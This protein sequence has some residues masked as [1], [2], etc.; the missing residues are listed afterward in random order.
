MKHLAVF[1]MFLGLVIAGCGTASATGF[2]AVTDELGYQGTVWNIT[3][4]TGPWTTSI[5]RDAVLYTVVNAAQVYSDYNMVATNW[6]EHSISNQNNSFFQFGEA[7]NASVT[8][9]G[10]FWSAD[11]KTFTMTV[12]GAGLPYSTGTSRFWQPDTVNGV[13]WGVTFTDYS[14][15]FT[16]TFANA[17]VLDQYG[18]YVNSNPDTIQGSLT[19]QF[20]VT[21]DVNKNPITNGDTYGFN[22]S[23]SK[24]MLD[25]L[26]PTS[27]WDGTAVTPYAEFGATEA[28]P[29]PGAI[30]LFAPGLVGLAAV[31]RRFKK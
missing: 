12:S 15:T 1:L 28:V 9:A 26:D 29:I 19:G 31:R 27:G 22:I 4:G 20:V 10:A 14:Y 24:A 23:L 8:S 3:L 2:Y 11:L 7:G 13:A 25:P 17:A 16:A 5:P 6:S 18:F 30:F 21:D